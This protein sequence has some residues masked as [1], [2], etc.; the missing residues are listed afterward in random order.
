[1][2]EYGQQRWRMN[3]VGIFNFWYYVDQEIQLEDGRLILRGANGSGKSVTMQSFL[4]L[5]LDGD[6]RPHRLDPFGS[7]DR[8]IEYYLLGEN[9]SGKQDVTGYLWMEFFH[10]GKQLFKTIGIGLRA[11]RGA[12]QV[13]F[14]GF[15]IEDGRRINQNFWLYN[16]PEWVETGAKV[17]LGRRE[18]AEKIA[19]GGQVVQEQAAYRDLVNKTL[20]G[21]A[22]TDG[23]QDLLQLLVRLRS[24]KLS[25][26]FKPTSMYEILATALPP[27]QDDDLR[28]LSEVLEDMDQ[29][30]DRL[31]ELRIH[32]KDMARLQEQYDRYNQFQ[33]YTAS[34]RV[35]EREGVFDRQAA[36]VGKVEREHQAALSAKAE[37]AQALVAVKQRQS[38]VEAELGI[39]EKH[40]AIEKQREYETS[41][42][43]LRDKEKQLEF[44]EAQT[45]QARTRLE[46]VRQ[47]EES[48]TT[49]A[50][51]QLQEQD[52]LLNELEELAQDMEFGPH[53]VYHRYWSGGAPKEDHWREPWK[54]DIRSHKEALNQALALARKE[55]EAYRQV[56]EIERQLGEAAKEREGAEVERGKMEAG[57]EHG[58]DEYRDRIVQ[59]RSGLALLPL[60]DDGVRR[61]LA[62]VREYGPVLRDTEIFRKP[63]LEAWEVRKDELLRQRGEWLQREKAWKEQREKVS[64]EKRSWET[65]RDPEPART[66]ARI[67]S[68]TGR[69]L[70]QGAPLYTV[71]DFRPH[72]SEEERARLEDALEQAGLL[73]AWIYPDGRMGKRGEGEEEA[74]IIPAPHEIGYTLA[75]LLEPV[76]PEDSGLKQPMIDTVLRT[77]LWEADEEG[78][79]GSVFA[80]VSAGGSYRLGPLAGK[81]AGKTR[82]AY[83]GHETRKRT[84]QL[85]IARLA[86]ELEAIGQELQACVN[87]LEETDRKLEQLKQEAVSFPEPAGLQ[88]ALDKLINAEAL[89][90]QLLKVE[91]RMEERVKV[92]TSEWRRLQLQLHEA[93]SEWS[94]LKREEQ[95]QQGLSS[96][97]DYEHAM[98]DLHTAWIQHREAVR[99]RVQLQEQVAE[100]QDTLDSY[101]EMHDELSDD[102]RRLSVQ[103]DKLRQLIEELGLAEIAH[104]LESLKRE[105]LALQEREANLHE[106]RSH[107]DRQEA[108]LEERL[109]SSRTSLTH[110]EEAMLEAWSQW[111]REMKRGLLR[112][113]AES[114]RADS[115]PVQLR[116]LCR[117]MQDQYAPFCEGR[118]P[119]RI[120]NSLLEDYNQV[121]L[122]LADYVLEA[123]VEETTGRIVLLSMR[124]RSQPHVPRVVLE[125]LLQAEE[126]QS[127]LLSE[128]DKELYEEIILRSVG[129]AIRQKI[130]RAEQWVKQMNGLMEERNT[131]SGLRLKLEWIPRPAQNENQLD[132]EQL[133]E[134]MKRDSHRLHEVEIEQIIAHFRSHI[135]YAKHQASEEQE[136]LRK[137]LYE[138]L[139]YRNWFVF[140][141]KYAKG[142]QTAYRPLTDSRFNVLSGGEK[143]MAM[144]IPL[145]AATYSRYSDGRSD[146]PRIISLDEAFAGVDEENMKDMFQLLTEMDFD[147]MMTSQVLWGCYDTVPK[148]SIYEVHRPK[149]ADWVTLFHYRWNGRYKEY[150]QEAVSSATGV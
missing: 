45:R 122:T 104:Q 146:A 32:R 46:R 116:K 125:E 107:A 145:F 47:E 4:P 75:D 31:E 50:Q 115:D 98:S 97:A 112:E 38:D 144:Y 20:F 70:G 96:A 26:E 11:R 43:T 142:E 69:G 110:S 113:W 141:L 120:S 28:P 99:Q 119:D 10:P 1:M 49:V 9:D 80:G 108:A 71:C 109:K 85:E 130:H 35:L 52:S 64:E 148:L 78:M 140:Q 84:R 105:K 15:V 82:A 72:L 111:H 74:W 33:L 13:G 91:E 29:I 5:V 2:E 79:T 135:G 131:S 65:N 59:W 30:T 21:F 40:E 54:R 8:R 101:Q 58:K 62:A 60:S 73:D 118:N 27:L 39:L 114:Y 24:P 136:S 149:D 139:D 102:C 7:K 68:R 22:D 86:A 48:A 95:L 51:K 134:L 12:A 103:V 117:E 88:D 150:V 53:S 89:L 126:E 66:Q 57:L 137:H 100:L 63:V 17:P 44:T 36:E 147:Y 55:R 121:R 3:R 34:G 92:K 16:R 123:E 56:Q 138:V 106:D 14:W 90:S 19:S 41:R 143:A 83:I 132:T 23:Y 133:V 76:V 81:A 93:T 87:Q 25:K 124:N 67:E 77:F 42:G 61:S 128:R 18:L 6:K 94:G 37:A 127:Q 129:K